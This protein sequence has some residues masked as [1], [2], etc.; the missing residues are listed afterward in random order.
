MQADGWWALPHGLAQAGIR[1]QVLLEM[2]QA[3]RQRRRGAAPV[4]G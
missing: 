2:W 4:L 3:W 1:R